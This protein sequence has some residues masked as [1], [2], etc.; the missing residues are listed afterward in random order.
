MRIW[1]KKKNHTVR[2]SK[3]EMPSPL[4]SSSSS[5][6]Q[7]PTGCHQT[8]H[9]TENA[10]YDPPRKSLWVNVNSLV[11]GWL[12]KDPQ[13]IKKTK[14]W[15]CVKL[16]DI[17]SMEEAAAVSHVQG[18]ALS[19]YHYIFSMQHLN[20]LIQYFWLNPMWD[21]VK[22]ACLHTEWWGVGAC[23]MT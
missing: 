6:P 9:A 13:W 15:I 4:L 1:K 19:S 18:K 20:M 23:N 17:S 22:W 3:I 12:A 2:V 16:F 14:G 10:L 8:I 5:P 11:T 21:K 7:G